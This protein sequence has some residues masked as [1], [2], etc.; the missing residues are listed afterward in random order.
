MT[1]KYYI[2][3]HNGQF[4]SRFCYDVTLVVEDLSSAR[5]FRTVESAREMAQVMSR[6]LGVHPRDSK[7]VAFMPTSISHTQES[8]CRLAVQAPFGHDKYECRG[9]N[10][11]SRV[12]WRGE[13]KDLM[14]TCM[15]RCHRAS[16][17]LRECT[18][19]SKRKKL[20]TCEVLPLL[21]TRST[22]AA[23]FWRTER[24]RGA[25]RRWRGLD[26]FVNASTQDSSS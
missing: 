15:D 11:K 25:N 16:C 8:P 4:I 5:L 19:T 17:R 10:R 21:S 7:S 24:Q 12:A 23:G 3:E 6:R 9:G 14:N 20:R 18:C 26:V 1:T 13:R 22:D 2:I